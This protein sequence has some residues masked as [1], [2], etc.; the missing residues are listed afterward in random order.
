MKHQYV[1]RM[2]HWV[3]TVVPKKGEAYYGP[4]K[5][6]AEFHRLKRDAM[7]A[8]EAKSQDDSV[9]GCIVCRVGVIRAHHDRTWINGKLQK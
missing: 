8:A 9:K 3:V 7:A 5:D 6:T 1:N 2:T 4:T